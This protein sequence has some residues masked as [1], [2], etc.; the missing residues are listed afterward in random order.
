MTIEKRK[1]TY[2]TH[3]YYDVRL[4]FTSFDPSEL[5]PLI[6][7]YE[8]R[9]DNPETIDYEKYQIIFD[10]VKHL[11]LKLDCKVFDISKL[12]LKNLVTLGLGYAFN[13]KI[14]NI[15][16]IQT[17]KAFGSSYFYLHNSVLG[18]EYLEY[19]KI[20][21]IK[22]K[23]LS[24]FHKL[25][26]LKQ[27]WFLD[28]TIESFDGIEAIKSLEYIKL[29]TCPKLKKIDKIDQL[30]NLVILILENNPK[31]LI[32]YSLVMKLKNLKMLILDNQ[33]EI[34]TLEFLRNHPSLE[35]IGLVGNTK[36]LDGN[37]SVLLEVPKLKGLTFDDKRGYNMKNKDV[38][39]NKI[40]NLNDMAVLK[41]NRRADELYGSP[42]V[43]V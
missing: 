10:N 13:T 37:L 22:E 11:G 9:I 7:H 1:S 5:D 26:N 35:G 12:N 15:D 38:P 16:Q 18:C 20:D 14:I 40:Y 3:Y 34:E 33:G 42:P 41:Y 28:R 32:D 23:D 4:P 36:I 31:A 17:L 6:T 29:G 19:M 8:I 24:S 21:K 27:F 25:K 2:S 30:S 43:I 39:K